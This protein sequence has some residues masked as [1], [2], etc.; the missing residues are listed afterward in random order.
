MPSIVILIYLS[1]TVSVGPTIWASAAGSW[2][3]DAPARQQPDPA[4]P[5]ADTEEDLADKLI[6]QSTGRAE[7][8]VMGHI[9]RLM[10]RSADL[11]TRDFE[12]GAKTQGT[13]REIIS[14]LDDAIA[15]AQRNRSRSNSSGQ[16]SGDKRQAKLQAKKQ[17]KQRGDPAADQASDTTAGGSADDTRVGG[18]RRFKESRRGWGHLPARDRDE[19]L[20]GIGESVLE[21]YRT[22][23]DRYFRALAEDVDRETE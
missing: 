18:D 11:L 2:P 12:P 3:P 10:E 8:G 7:Q 9:Q 16:Q 22:L 20:Q 6:R 1:I 17:G 5:P 21:K 19:V 14:K 4:D 23:I 13:Q 15:T